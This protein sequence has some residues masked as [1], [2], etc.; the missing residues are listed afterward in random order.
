MENNK[1]NEEKLKIFRKMFTGL[2]NVYGTYDPETGRS[3]QVKKTVTD[4]VF[5]DHLLGRTPYGI[6]LLN[7]DKTRAVVI[8]FDEEN[9]LLPIEFI[10]SAKHYKI[11]GYIERSKSKG[12]HVWIFFPEEGVPAGKARL[13]AKHILD[14]IDATDTEIFPKQDEL[15]NNLKY[16]NF[17]N[18]PLFGPLVK[19]G[20]TVFLNPA[21]FKPY[22]DQ[23]SFLDSVDFVSEQ[24]LNDIIEI[25][26]WVNE[27]PLP[28]AKTNH[29][30]TVSKSYGLPICAQRMLQDGVIQNQ[31][32]SCFRLA[33]HCKRLGFPQ[34]IA[35]TI[36]T[37]WSQKNKPR[38]PKQIISAEEINNQTTS[39][40]ENN[41]QGY[42]CDTEETRPFCSPDCPVYKFKIKDKI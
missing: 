33:V 35:I 31:R 42:G 3:R 19:K 36:L 7:S 22:D 5:L 12:Y 18:A 39:A 28:P 10:N 24:T 41:Y 21:T 6:Y 37:A 8:D 34:D 1:N 20:R 23:W 25:N 11:S 4:C 27:S 26:E 30:N 29:I 14:E 32:V 2:P 16:G 13:V 9:R 40:Y 38:P 17:I 15:S